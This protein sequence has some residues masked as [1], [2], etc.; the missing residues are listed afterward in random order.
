MNRECRVR[1]EDNERRQGKERTGE[2]GVKDGV[3][4]RRNE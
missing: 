2:G 3:E 4:M 1:E